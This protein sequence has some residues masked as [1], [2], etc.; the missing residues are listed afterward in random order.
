M[1]GYKKV[2]FRIKH[3]TVRSHC[4]SLVPALDLSCIPLSLGLGT[5]PGSLIEKVLCA[6]AAAGE[7]KQEA[8]SSPRR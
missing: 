2:R 6:V 7:Y 4:P 1:E 5:K 8:T 3:P